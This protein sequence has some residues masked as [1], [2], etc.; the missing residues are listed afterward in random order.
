MLLCAG[1]VGV[2]GA[3]AGPAIAAMAVRF[4]GLVWGAATRRL[5]W[6]AHPEMVWLGAISYTLYLSH[7]NI[8][9]S[10]LLRLQDLGVPRDAGIAIAI[11]PRTGGRPVVFGVMAVDA[12]RITD[13]SNPDGPRAPV[14]KATV[15]AM[16]AARLAPDRVLWQHGEADA[17]AGTD[18]DR[19]ARE[20]SRVADRLADQGVRAPWV[21]AQS[22]V[23]RSAPA[24]GRRGPDTDNLVAPE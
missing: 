18:P 14:L 4:G 20:P 13:W 7:E 11:D 8:G 23:C 2:L 1:A 22:T 10:L 17:R 3:E 9:W 15:S 6:L 16:L 24:E 21:L 5:P 12:T 19:Y